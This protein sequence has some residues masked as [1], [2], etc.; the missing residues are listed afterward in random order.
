MNWVP[1]GPWRNVVARATYLR[2]YGQNMAA[3][4]EEELRCDDLEMRDC[5]VVNVM[6]E[7]RKYIRS[8]VGLDQVE[9]ICT[10]GVR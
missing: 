1:F 7:A 4:A 5:Y 3:S 10:G 6:E 8:Q 9:E 2:F